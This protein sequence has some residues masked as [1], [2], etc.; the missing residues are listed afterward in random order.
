M[1]VREMKVEDIKLAVK[2]L[3]LKANTVLRPDVLEG[4]KRLYEQEPKGTQAKNMLKILVENAEIADK[5]NIPICQDTGLVVVFLEI[6]EDVH[7]YGGD[8][9]QAVNE[10]VEEAYR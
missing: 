3:S 7:F 8:L 1:S 10:G 5:K 4:I 6:G 9:I 2:E